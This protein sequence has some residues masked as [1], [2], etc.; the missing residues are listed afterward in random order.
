[1]P[2]S[3]D[4]EGSVTITAGEQGS[5]EQGTALPPGQT[6]SRWCPKAV[7]KPGPAAAAGQPQLRPLLPP[8]PQTS[9]VIPGKADDTESQ[10]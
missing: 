8:S 7:S 3:G 4:A 1:M 10:R 6:Q 9:S 5:A 2:E